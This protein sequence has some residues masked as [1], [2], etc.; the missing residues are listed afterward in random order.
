[1]YLED[2]GGLAN[3][4]TATALESAIRTQNER[5]ANEIWLWHND[6]RFPALAIL[7]RHNAAYAQY[8]PEAGH[9]G[10]MSL[11][12]SQ[13]AELSTTFYACSAGEEQEVSS[14]NVIPLDV[15]AA[16]AQ[17]FFV[18]GAQPE[19]IDWFEL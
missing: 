10:F 8:F 3:I 19:S 14:G 13:A 15:A 5:G 2:I 11:A 4:Q 9:P 1:M 6:L 12:R 18:S 16:V 7:T 17:E